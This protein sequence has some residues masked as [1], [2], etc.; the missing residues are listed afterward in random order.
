MED[1]YLIAQKKL[2]KYGQEQ[3]LN[4]YNNLDK[5]KQE[6]LLE[7]ILDINFEQMESLYEILKQ[8]NKNVKD[9]IE[10]IS[11]VN[12][13]KISEKEKKYFENIGQEAIKKGQ[14]AVVTMAGGQRN[15]TRT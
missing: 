10:P 9:I 6:K 8:K 12:K 3:L 7:D 4:C 15:K 5:N 1:K 11:Y 2:K 14:Y 13:E